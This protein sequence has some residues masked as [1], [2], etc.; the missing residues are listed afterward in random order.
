MSQTASIIILSSAIVVVIAMIPFTAISSSNSEN[1]EE[2]EEHPL[3]H[4]W[5]E[6]R[7]PINPN[8]APDESCDI[9]AYQL[10]CIPGSEQDCP[11]GFGQNEDYVCAPIGPCPDDYHGEDDDETG[12]CYPDSEGCSNDEYYILREREDGKG[13]TCSALYYLC[14]DSSDDRDHPA[15]KEYILK[16]ITEDLRGLKT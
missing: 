8:F 7:G 11:D 5:K 4:V 12:Q 3:S 2:P 13:K 15:C 6:K 14:S 9:N 16:K 1:E 10:K